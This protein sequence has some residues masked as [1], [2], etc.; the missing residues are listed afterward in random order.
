VAL[1]CDNS[2]VSRTSQVREALLAAEQ[3]G[4]EAVEAV[5]QEADRY[6]FIKPETALAMQSRR[7]RHL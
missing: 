5:H 3:V 2:T 7:S 6:S 1:C 4:A